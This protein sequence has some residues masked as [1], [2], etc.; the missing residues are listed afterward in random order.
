MSDRR[1]HPETREN[2]QRVWGRE[3]SGARYARTDRQDRYAADP[4]GRDDQTG[5]QG[6][7]QD[8]HDAP[9]AR[10]RDGGRAAGHPGAQDHGYRDQGYQDQAYHEQGYQDPAYQ[11]QGYRDH[12]FRQDEYD[13]PERGPWGEREPDDDYLD[14]PPKRRWGRRSNVDPWDEP[15]DEEPRRKL[16]GRRKSGDEAATDAGHDD[17]PTGAQRAGRGGHYEMARNDAD[18]ADATASAAAGRGS[19]RAKGRGGDGPPGGPPGGGP[20]SRRRDDSGGGKRG[21]GVLGWT[22]VALTTVM[23]ASTLTGYKIY[24]DTFKLIEQ[25]ASDDDLDK[26]RPVNQTGA[27]NVLL[28]GSDTRAGNNKKYGQHMQNDGERTD[29]IMLLHIAPNRDGATLISFPRDSMVAI[30]ECH[31]VRTKAVVP[32]H[33]GMINSAFSSGGMICTRRTIETL[34]Q[35]HIDHYVKVDFSGF[36]N[37]VNALGGIEICVPRD[38]N[39]KK[40][41]LVLKKG[42]QTVRGETALAY[43]RTRYGLGNGGD[44]DRIQRQQIFISQVVK[45]ATSSELLTDFGKLKAFIEAAAASVKTDNKLSADVILEIAK[46]ASKLSAKGF[47]A[48][49]VPWEP[50][51]A[52][53][54]RVQWKQPAANNL[55]AGI[56]GDV[57]V[58]ASPSPSA[59]ASGGAPPAAPTV[60]KPEQVKVQVF[61]GT[62]TDGKGREVAEA[63]TAQGFRVVGVGD[64]RKPDGSDQPTTMIRYTGQGWD[65]AK[66]LSGKLLNTVQPETGKLAT[67]PVMPFASAT[68]PPAQGRVSGPIIQLVVGAD[69]EGVKVALDVGDDA[70]T[71][72]TDI[73]AG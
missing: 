19:R 39:D 58:T 14:D 22:S 62:N 24:R 47:K 71:S 30:P 72:E 15:D 13:E 25:E 53:K 23:V 5:R 65:Q 10:R 3:E 17:E 63:L 56:R 2:D 57:E 11:D 51:V 46:S 20:R 54:N 28:V 61:N 73:C 42:T 41:K 68:A 55:F 40:A 33:F 44:I 70:V 45:K 60:T 9:R 12:G 8:S 1:Q 7:Y 21:L 26:N 69:W 38:V 66:I 64:A 36:K 35:I 31:D 50:Y 4:R 16:W 67:G 37:I 18:D 34:T 29:T 27:L 59:S 32:A 48:K 49:T 6:A 52:D 43:V